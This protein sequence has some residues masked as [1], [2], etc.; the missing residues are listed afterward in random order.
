MR[1]RFFTQLLFHDL[2]SVS[3]RFLYEF[4]RMLHGLFCKL[5]YFFVLL[6][7]VLAKTNTWLEASHMR[8]KLDS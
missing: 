3:F 5:M 4:G 6:Y 2:I 8:S 7:A 1:G